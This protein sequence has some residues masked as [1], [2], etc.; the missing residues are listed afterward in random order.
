ML[1]VELEGPCQIYFEI[2]Y[3][4]FQWKMEH[5]NSKE[6]KCCKESIS[7]VA[8]SKRHVNAPAVQ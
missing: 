2:L 4:S 5:L 3:S 7:D 8:M 6:S 1:G